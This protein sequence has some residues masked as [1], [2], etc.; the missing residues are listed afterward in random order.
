M[1]VSDTYDAREDVNRR[2]ADSINNWLAFR[3]S[4]H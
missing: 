2:I 4:G 1:Q 3:A